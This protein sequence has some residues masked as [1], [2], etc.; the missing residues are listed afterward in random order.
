M[1]CVT[2]KSGLKMQWKGK[3]GNSFSLGLL[4][5]EFKTMEETEDAAI[6]A[7]DQRVEMRS[8]AYNREYMKA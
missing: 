7:R 1:S 8:K 4:L 3:N 6:A 5:T 2:D